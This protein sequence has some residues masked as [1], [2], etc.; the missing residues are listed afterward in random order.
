MSK[1]VAV[2]SELSRVVQSHK[3]MNVSELEQDIVMQSDKN[4][5]L[6]VREREGGEERELRNNA[7]QA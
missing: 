5:H 3:L 7:Y 2:V 6:K 1:H 4:T